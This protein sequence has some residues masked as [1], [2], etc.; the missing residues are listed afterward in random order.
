MRVVRGAAWGAGMTF[1]EEKFR[2]WFVTEGSKRQM[3]LGPVTLREDLKR[4][5]RN[6]RACIDQAVL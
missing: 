3:P 1:K 2:E 5:P 4:L 6:E